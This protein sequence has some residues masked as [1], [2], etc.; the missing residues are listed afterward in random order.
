MFMADVVVWVWMTS[1]LSGKEDDP[2]HER[3]AD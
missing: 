1:G 3:T 2:Q